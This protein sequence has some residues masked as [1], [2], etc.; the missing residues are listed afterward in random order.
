M[1]YPNNEL[2]LVLTHNCYNRHEELLRGSKIVH[3]L[4]IKTK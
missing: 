2:N 3:K 1:I 4:M